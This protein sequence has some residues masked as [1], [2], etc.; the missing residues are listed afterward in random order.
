MVRFKLALFGQHVA[1]R[2]GTTLEIEWI[3]PWC[4]FLST[5]C[6]REE[7]YTKL[8]IRGYAWWATISF[9]IGY[10]AL[11]RLRDDIL[12]LLGNRRSLPVKISWKCSYYH[13]NEVSW[14]SSNRGTPGVNRAGWE[15]FLNGVEG[16]WIYLGGLMDFNLFLIGGDS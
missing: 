2:A 12:F 7:K 15:S 8:A 4:M 6:S 1:N 9:R 14:D 5:P 16:R 10:L 13:N 11:K 3:G